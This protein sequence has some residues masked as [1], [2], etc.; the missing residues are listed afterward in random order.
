MDVESQVLR[1]CLVILGEGLKDER[2]IA[3]LPVFGGYRVGR[4]WGIR[5]LGVGLVSAEEVCATVRH[6][7]EPFEAGSLGLGPVFLKG[8]RPFGDPVLLEFLSVGVDILPR[9]VEPAG[10]EWKV[11]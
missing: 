6:V 3:R 1:F 8:L 2:R 7:L 5:D 9:V 10:E 4:G 11:A